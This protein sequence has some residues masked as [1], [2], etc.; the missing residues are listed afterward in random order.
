MLKSG[1]IYKLGDGPFNFDWNMRYIVLDEANMTLAYFM[2]ERDS[3]PRGIIP[4]KGALISNVTQIKEREHSFSVQTP[5]PN[6]HTFF[7]SCNSLND[8]V[9]WRECFVKATRASNFLTTKF[10]ESPIH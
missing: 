3:E 10:Q 7:F 9:S 2:N 6:G 4:L 8:S 1:Y 5:P